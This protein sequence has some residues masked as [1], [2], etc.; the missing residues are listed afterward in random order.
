MTVDT[1]GEQPVAKPG[2]SVLRRLRD[3][4]GWSVLGNLGW[5]SLTAAS[6][7]LV[8]RVLG[9]VG[10][11]ELGILRSTANILTT[12]AVFR[13][14]T[15]AN[16]HV[17]E[18][19][20][21]DPVRAA[22]ILSMTLFVS[23]VLCALFGA[24]L[25]F[26]GGYIATTYL[27]NP[28]LSLPL[29]VGS[30]F[31]FCQAYSAVRETILIGTEQFRAYARVN[32]WKGATTAVLMPVGAWFWGVLGATLGLS[33]AALL[34]FVILEIHVRK[35]LAMHGI[36]GNL[37]FREWRSEVSILWTFALPGL[38]TGLMTAGC[39]WLGRVHLAGAENGFQ[40]LG[41]FEAANQWRTMILFVPGSLSLVA[42]PIIAGTYGQADKSEFHKAV[43][44]QFNGILAIALPVTVVTICLSDWLMV[45][46][47]DAYDDGAM[48]LPALMI[49][50]A[51]FALNQSLRK[52]MDGTGHVWR[53][54]ALSVIWALA[55]LLPLYF[56]WEEPTAISL[57]YAYLVAEAVMALASLAYIIV[58]LSRQFLR[59]TAIPILIA[60]GSSGLSVFAFS[61]G[62]IALMAVSVILSLAP[63]GYIY[64]E[65]RT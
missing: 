28:G 44:L 31:M 48:V 14:G 36:K 49:S 56:I 24:V 61:E 35:A 65:Y 12:L 42:L 53:H 11:G 16:K 59:Q 19:R 40:E 58:L 37:P 20:E 46:F 21:T 38:I 2:K 17:A 4:F 1:S 23:A 55:F 43:S 52:I 30:V 45:I 13:L 57:A 33:L 39:Y 41:L 54:T 6:S 29:R 9:P 26:G 64:L 27:N 3:G 63:L 51:L 7:V 15:T 34:S 10:F 22:R 8:A 25:L 18:F 47:G 60:I 5:R 32:I 62:S 50:V